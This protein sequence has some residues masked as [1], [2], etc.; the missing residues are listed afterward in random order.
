VIHNLEGGRPPTVDEKKIKAKWDFIF[1]LYD[2]NLV[3]ANHDIN[4]GGILITISEMCFKNKL[5]AD[6]DFKNCYDKNLRD[7]EFLFSESV[8]RFIIETHP[9]D[10]DLILDLAKRF[11]V[12]INK[13]G[14]LNS[15]PIIKISGLKSENFK[16]SLENMKELYDSTIPNLME[17]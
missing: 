5:G 6:L 10:H 2:R 7:D 9:K 17:I 16:L 12:V 1:E 8:G 13:I 15:K 4:K 14:V 3:K 11:N